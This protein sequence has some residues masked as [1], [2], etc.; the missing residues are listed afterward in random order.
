MKTLMIFV[1]ISASLWGCL[2]CEFVHR[3]NSDTVFSHHFNM[4]RDMY[5]LVTNIT[6]TEALTCLLNAVS[7]TCWGSFSGLWF[8]IFHSRSFFSP[9]NHSTT[10]VTLSQML[11]WQLLFS[12]WS[13]PN[14]SIDLTV[15]FSKCYLLGQFQLTLA[16]AHMRRYLFQESL[17]DHLKESHW[18]FL[19]S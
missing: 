5:E 16:T 14:M 1:F 11:F 18:W 10:V 19:C 15:E 6:Q 8:P 4:A 17:S 7:A 2:D 3:T 12:Y 13:Y 9:N